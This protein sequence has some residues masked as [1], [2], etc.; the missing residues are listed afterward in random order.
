M[1]DTADD[2]EYDGNLTEDDLED[3][4]VELNFFRALQFQSPSPPKAAPK[5]ITKTVSFEE[6][7]EGSFRKEF[8]KETLRAVFVEVSEEG[9]EELD[10]ASSHQHTKQSETSSSKKNTHKSNGTPRFSGPSSK[11][12]TDKSKDKLES[13]NSQLSSAGKSKRDF[14]SSLQTIGPG[15]KSKNTPVDLTSSLKQQ[16]VT[17]QE[18][19]QDTVNF[20][21]QQLKEEKAKKVPDSSVPALKKEIVTLKKA[22]ADSETQREALEG[23]LATLR[24]SIDGKVKTAAFEA[25]K[26]EGL[27]IKQ[28]EA[29]IEQLKAELQKTKT[30]LEVTQKIKETSKI[31]PKKPVNPPTNPKEEKSKTKEPVRHQEKS[32][33]EQPRQLDSDQKFEYTPQKPRYIEGLEIPNT[34]E[35]PEKFKKAGEEPLTPK[36]P[37]IIYSPEGYTDLPIKKSP[38]KNSAANDELE[39]LK[40]ENRKLHEHLRKMLNGRPSNLSPN[41]QSTPRKSLSPITSS[42]VKN[43]IDLEAV[44]SLIAEV[45]PALNIVPINDSTIEINKK[46]LS[47]LNSGGKVSVKAKDKI[48]DLKEYVRS[49]FPKEININKKLLSASKQMFE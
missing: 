29:S 38:D 8:N 43:P 18:D 10:E 17:S 19:L 42:H 37:S 46:R 16:S 30:E 2:D 7:R 47:L 14:F 36:S 21:L 15:G 20:L 35:S 27:K 39:K 9:T 34:Y 45:N 31:T 5:A 40:A 13:S 3:P 11:N 49:Q 41:S 33:D 23:Q 44:S 12:H 6:Q 4:L 24:E 22:L 48:V 32:D 1:F 26:K 25:K 28:L